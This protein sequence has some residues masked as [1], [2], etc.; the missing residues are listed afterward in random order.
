MDSE[1]AGNQATKKMTT[2]KAVVRAVGTHCAR[3][4]AE[5]WI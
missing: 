1:I 2:T 5:R 4:D 3:A